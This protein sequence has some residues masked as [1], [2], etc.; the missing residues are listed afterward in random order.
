MH[1]AGAIICNRVDDRCDG[2]EFSGSFIKLHKCCE[3]PRKNANECHDV[4]N[5]QI[6]RAPLSLHEQNSPS[7]DQSQSYES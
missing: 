2:D 1:H 4:E 6:D 7:I 5:E 3:K